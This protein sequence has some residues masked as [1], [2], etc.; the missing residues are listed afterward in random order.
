MHKKRS[1]WLV[2][3][4]LMLTMLLLLAAMA[5]AV[6]ASESSSATPAQASENG[7]ANC[8]T[9]Q[10]WYDGNRNGQPDTYEDLMDGASVTLLGVGPFKYETGPYRLESHQLTRSGGLYSF[11]D[12]KPG[13]YE[14]RFRPSENFI[15]LTYPLHYLNGMV[16]IFVVPFEQYTQYFLSPTTQNSPIQIELAKDEHA[17]VNVGFGY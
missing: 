6:Q 13:T 1:K 3:R 2:R 9:G 15:V 17:V 12:L 8:I 7:L 4:T 10:V 5:A 16:V 11:C 14:L